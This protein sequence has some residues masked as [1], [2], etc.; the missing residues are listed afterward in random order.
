MSDRPVYTM[1]TS[2]LSRMTTMTFAFAGLLV[3]LLGLHAA[4]ARAQVGGGGV[5]PIPAFTQNTGGGGAS[6]T[7]ANKIYGVNPVVT[8]DPS[9]SYLP[10][11]PIGQTY[12][13]TLTWDF[14]DASSVVTSGPSTAANVLGPV[15]HSFPLPPVFPA[16]A[17]VDPNTKDGGFY[18]ITLTIDVTVVNQS[19]VT[20][21]GPSGT[22][23][24]NVR[25]AETNFGPKPTLSNNSSPSNGSLPYQ[26]NLNYA[27]THDEDG[28]IIWAAISWG[29]GSSDLLTQKLPSTSAIPALHSYTAPGTYMVTLSVIDN[30]RMAPNTALDP[31]PNANDPAG[32]LNLIK[33]VQH[34]LIDTG[35]LVGLIDP[36]T[37]VSIFNADKFLPILRQDNL[38]I[39]VPGNLMV[40]KGQFG[41]DFTTAN[42]DS[43]DTTFILDGA[44][45][46]VAAAKISLFLGYPKPTLPLSNPIVNP[47]ASLI[48]NPFTT[49]LK[50]NYFNS[51]QGLK[52]SIDP[53]KHFMRIQI[54]QIALQKALVLGSATVVNGFADIPVTIVINSADGSMTA[55]STKLRFAYNATAGQRGIGKNPRSTMLGN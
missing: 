48:L 36:N 7:N 27:A 49:D 21:Q 3:V 22:T 34:K 52:F 46:S 20:S 16:N 50:G 31:T 10:S 33:G 19:N 47:P 4:S 1:E 40:V 8:F 13:Y 54:K 42:N 37:G 15:T 11:P 24:G 25:S 9:T 43:F 51:A 45:S 32:A 30:G 38:Q 5:V 53:R 6:G 12:L 18:T 26:V 23:Y 17:G 55:L 29:D 35:V 14:G 41:L 39:Q 44:V 28:Y 2:L